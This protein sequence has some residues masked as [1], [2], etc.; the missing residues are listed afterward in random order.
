MKMLQFAI[1]C[2]SVSITVIAVGVQ[3]EC[4]SG[5]V[6]DFCCDHTFV[7]RPSV[8]STVH[9]RSGDVLLLV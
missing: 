2:Q 1:S 3:E 4:T 7:Q 5:V 9:I 6:S 8:L